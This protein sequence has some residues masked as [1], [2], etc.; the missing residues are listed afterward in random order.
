M[1]L[2]CKVSPASPRDPL[3]LQAYYEH[4]QRAQTQRFELMWLHK[5]IVLFKCI[6]ACVQK[7]QSILTFSSVC[8]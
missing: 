3:V 7:L 2:L 1:S 8:N 5:Y 4:L 6:S